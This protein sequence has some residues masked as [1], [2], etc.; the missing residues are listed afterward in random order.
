MTLFKSY[1]EHGDFISSF[2]DKLYKFP[3][4]TAS[5]AAVIFQ[6]QYII[7][8]S[9]IMS[10]PSRS[11]STAVPH[12]YHSENLWL[13]LCLWPIAV[14]SLKFSFIFYF[15]RYTTITASLS[16]SHSCFH[17]AKPLNED[18]Y[19]FIDTSKNWLEALRIILHARSKWPVEL[20]LPLNPVQ[21]FLFLMSLLLGW[22]FETISNTDLS[23]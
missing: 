16:L 20:G 2:L 9:E 21:E 8:V 12:L 1:H 6:T 3:I 4:I 10:L 19:S 23:F 7:F 15:M 13:P 22:L 5:E 17:S 18:K 14:L 11:R